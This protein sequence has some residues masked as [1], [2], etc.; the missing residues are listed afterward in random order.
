METSRTLIRRFKALAISALLFTGIAVAQEDPPSRVLRLNYLSGNV[1]MQP[2]G[3]EEW[4]PAVINRPLTVDDYLYTDQNSAAELQTDVAV[5]RMGQYSH[6]GVL[7][8]TDTVVQL[9]LTAGD[10]SVRA[11]ELNPDEV[12]EVDTPNAAVTLLRDGVYR[13]HVDPEANT[14]FVVARTGQAEITGGGQSFTLN[15]GNSASLSGSDQLSFDIGIAPAPDSFDEWCTSRDNYFA[16][17]HSRYLPETVIGADDLDQYGAWNED[18]TYGYVWY[19]REVAPDW[20]PYH[21][22]H[23]A[24]VDPW[25]WTWVDDAS[26]GFAPF[27][28]GRWVFVSG[29]WGWAPGPLVLVRGRPYVRPVRPVYAPALVAWFGGAHWGVSASVGGPAVGWV[30][31]G[32]GEVYTPCYHVSPHYFERVN[33][34]NTRVVNNVN[35]TNVYRTVYVNK[36]VYN[37]TFVNVRARNAVVSM[38]QNSFASGRPVRSTGVVLRPEQVAQ[39]H[40]TQAVVVAPLAAPTRQALAPTLGRPA[41]RPPAQ[42]VSRPVVARVA[43]PVPSPAFVARQTIIQQHAGQVYNAAEVRQMVA[44]REAAR[45]QALVREAPPARPVLV[46]PGEHAGNAPAANIRNSPAQP[47]PA[48]G[49]NA[50]AAMPMAARPVSPNQPRPVPQDGVRPMPQPQYRRPDQQPEYRRQQQSQQPQQQFRPAQPAYREAQ[51][52]SSETPHAQPRVEPP[53]QPRPAPARPEQPRM[54]QPRVEE[55]RSE[56]PRMEQPRHEEHRSPEQQAR[57]ASPPQQT[58]PQQEH[59]ERPTDKRTQPPPDSHDKHER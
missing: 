11:H 21:Y 12:L 37:Q 59:H 45:A 1:S 4:A 28:Y 20:A 39:V 26:W 49:Q 14:T 52:N 53:P 47:A 34:A 8:L 10:L 30:P 9:K 46:H 32:F 5:I 16:Q 54:E 2:A 15:P 3:L 51:P 18:S 38:P 13:F 43:P 42:F 57:P 24:W 19:P 44:P 41:P 22:G 29:R 25:G 48:A 40:L 27:H 6:F 36:T 31:L 50:P 17:R 58:Q 23:W 33:V 35:I 56:Q 55:R 7:N